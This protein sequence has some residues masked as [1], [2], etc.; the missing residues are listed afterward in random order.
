MFSVITVAYNS[1][2]TIAETITS[3]SSQTEID[4]EHIIVDGCSTDKTLKVVDCHNHNKLKFI[5]EPDNGLYDAM[6][7]GLKMANGL[8]VAF[9]NSDDYFAH[10]EVLSCIKSV[11]LKNNNYDIICG[12][13]EFF[14]ANNPCI[15]QW[16]PGS[17]E[18][19]KRKKLQ[20]PHPGIFIKKSAIVDSDRLFDD[21]LSIAADLK[22]QLQIIHLD[23]RD[24][25]CL[26]DVIV[27]MRLGGKSTD[28]IRGY[29]VGWIESFRVYYQIFGLLGMFY[30]IR[31]VFV[32]LNQLKK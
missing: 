30:C 10:P 22:Q 14:D 27:K 31:K 25:K 3:V 18:L 28:G 7:K 12:G 24:G 17:F 11:Y 8:F 23:Q 29:L 26:S 16:L 9:L 6:N 32:K 19:I 15:R 20:L 13:L 5:S 4:F 21:T 2:A 1:E